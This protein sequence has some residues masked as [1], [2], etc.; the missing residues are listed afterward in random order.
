LYDELDRRR[1]AWSAPKIAVVRFQKVRG[2]Y[3]K[4]ASFPIGSKDEATALLEVLGGWL[5]RLERGADDPA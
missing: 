3:R 1:D 2:A 4:Q 5:P